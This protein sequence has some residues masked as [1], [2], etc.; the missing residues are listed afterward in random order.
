MAK[1]KTVRV[2]EGQPENTAQALDDSVPIVFNGTPNDQ[3]TVYSPDT[4]VNIITSAPEPET[5]NIPPVETP[6]VTQE[7]ATA[8]ATA[9]SQAMAMVMPSFSQMIN[10]AMKAH[11]QKPPTMAE[12][13]HGAGDR[14]TMQREIPIF[15]GLSLHDALNFLTADKLLFTNDVPFGDALHRT[16][17]VISRSGVREGLVALPGQEGKEKPAVESLKQTQI[18][19]QFG[20]YLLSL[21]E[22]RIPISISLAHDNI[23]FDG[24]GHHYWKAGE[25]YI[26][27]NDARVVAPRKLGDESPQS[28]IDEL[29]AGGS[30]VTNAM[31]ASKSSVPSR[32]QR[33]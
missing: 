19:K 2:Q 16:F 20:E 9:V 25:C 8:I 23:G 4:A 24:A 21:L 7:T 13:L 28:I 17:T 6:P 33:G 5:T 27:R 10:D 1:R 31:D 30:D 14:P 22:D 15:D 12:Q 32:P 18:N 26:F 29:S 3:S 11:G